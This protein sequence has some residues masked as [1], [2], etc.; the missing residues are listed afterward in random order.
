MFS[1]VLVCNQ[2]FT[3]IS[4]ITVLKFVCTLIRGN[5]RD[6]M[7]REKDNSLILT[8]QNIYVAI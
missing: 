8:L 3:D 1:G 4:I 6:L 2:T 7:Q 5:V